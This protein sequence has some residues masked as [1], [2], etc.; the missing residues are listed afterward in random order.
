MKK[1][2]AADEQHN[3]IPKNLLLVPIQ[4]SSAI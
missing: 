1:S 2:L 4:H 3:F